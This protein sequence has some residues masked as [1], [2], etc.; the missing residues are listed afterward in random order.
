[1]LY[2]GDRRVAEV[3]TGTRKIAE[4][5][6]GN[7]LVWKGGRMY[8]TYHR[9]MLILYGVG[10]PLEPNRLQ[11]EAEIGIDLRTEPYL[12]NGMQA[13]E[14]NELLELRAVVLPMA[15]KRGTSSGELIR[16]AAGGAQATAMGAT[17][18]EALMKAEGFPATGR[19]LPA[20]RLEELIRSELPAVLAA[21]HAADRKA[22]VLVYYA[23]GTAGTGAAGNLRKD[24]LA[25]ALSCAGP[26]GRA[27][28]KLV[29]MLHTSLT[30]AVESS[31]IVKKMAALVLWMTDGTR[32][33]G[34]AGKKVV[35]VLKGYM[36][37]NAGKGHAGSVSKE[38]I[39]FRT[40]GSGSYGKAAEHVGFVQRVSFAG[41]EAMVQ[42]TALK[43]RFFSSGESG[44]SVDKVTANMRRWLFCHVANGRA[45]ENRAGSAKGYIR[46]ST[47]AEG[48]SKE[49]TTGVARTWI[50]VGETAHGIQ[51][52]SEQAAKDSEVRIQGSAT[53]TTNAVEQM[54][55]KSVMQRNRVVAGKDSPLLGRTGPILCML[56]ATANVEDST[57]WD[58][59]QEEAILSMGQV[60]SVTQSDN[61]L[62][63]T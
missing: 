38:V 10:M 55:V 30:G 47:V 21:C 37:G 3:F 40:V 36:A 52:E 28:K 42:L 27:G 16:E 17:E 49:L 22:R 25:P 15:G 12:T 56:H 63:V 50:H 33:T 4:I 20:E 53:G 29:K 13:R 43:S 19:G 7:R 44:R 6:L 59:S 39:P 41:N 45:V 62:G 54:A 24:M 26:D 57:A 32:S 48:S 14:S 9:D 60:Y 46:V 31:G 5:Y 23:D 18:T 8:A 51:K 1:M 35:R 58:V 61:I 34:K 2:R 11:A